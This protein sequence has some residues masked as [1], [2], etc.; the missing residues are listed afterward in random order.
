[1]AEVV[2]GC[3]VI[4]FVEGGNSD[5]VII[6]VLSVDVVGVVDV[7]CDVVGLWVL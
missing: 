6:V 3:L 4:V 7:G 2:V 1:M 5:V